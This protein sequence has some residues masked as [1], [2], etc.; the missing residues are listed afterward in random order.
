MRR[1]SR[2]IRVAASSEGSNDVD[3]R[4][5]MSLGALFGGLALANAGLG[6]VHG[7]AAPIGA[8]FPAPH[9]AVCAALLPHGMA[10]N[11]RALR[12]RE[13]GHPA[14]ERYREIAVALTGD[15]TASADDGVAA[16]L[17]LV[18]D[19]QV[20]G[21]RSYGVTEDAVEMLCGKAGHASSMKTNPLAL[22]PDDLSAM[23]AAAL[24]DAAPLS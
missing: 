23:L 11:L 5:D 13:P 10:A 20:P 14:I 3:A 15:A 24:R 16:V 6:V 22:T 7:F 4:T 18:R 2:S 12:A 1:I 19:L 21:L 9:A 17:A 8:S